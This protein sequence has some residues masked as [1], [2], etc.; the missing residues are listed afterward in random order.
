MASVKL[1]ADGEVVADEPGTLLY[2]KAE[3]YYPGVETL[4]VGLKKDEEATGEV[5]IG[6]ET[7]LEHLAGK[8]CQAT[9]KVLGI[10]AQTVPELTDELAEELGYEGGVSGMRTAIQLKMQ[11]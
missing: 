7:A 1:E 11:N 3:R 9:V 2:T 10:Q 4:V 5:T 6:D 8:T